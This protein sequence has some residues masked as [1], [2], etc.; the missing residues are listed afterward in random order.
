MS[1][2]GVSLSL[3]E[4]GRTA[5]G[6]EIAER[7][8][9]AGPVIGRAAFIAIVCAVLTVAIGCLPF[10]VLQIRFGFART[11]RGKASETD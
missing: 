6:S 7:I 3:G 11:L 4:V 1:A 8:L 9:T 2:S 5:V 10:D